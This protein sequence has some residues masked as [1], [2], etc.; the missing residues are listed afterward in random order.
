[1]IKWLAGLHLWKL[2][3]ELVCVDV[4]LLNH[5]INVFDVCFEIF[6]GFSNAFV[7]KHSQEPLDIGLCHLCVFT[8]VQ[9]NSMVV[10]REDISLHPLDAS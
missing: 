4:V 3:L 6:F 5:L 2:L 10:S 1:M 9:I 7:P 8:H